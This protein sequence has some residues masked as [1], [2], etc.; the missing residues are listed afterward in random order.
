MKEYL[1]TRFEA[2]ASCGDAYPNEDN[3]FSSVT[4]GRL[5]YIANT[6]ENE[7]LNRTCDYPKK[8]TKKQITHNLV[9]V[10]PLIPKISLSL[11]PSLSTRTLL[12]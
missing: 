12:V 3:I 5:T 6:D 7:I 1:E 8:Q 10:A 4:K 9:R 11:F 2:D